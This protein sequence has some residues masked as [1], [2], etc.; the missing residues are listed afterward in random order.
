MRRRTSS[1]NPRGRGPDLA[2]A[3]VRARSFTVFVFAFD[4]GFGNARACFFTGWLG[5][6]LN[7]ARKKWSHLVYLGSRLACR[8]AL[9][10]VLFRIAAT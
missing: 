1:G 5:S 2:M 6:T 4:G 10:F 8:F 3:P 7:A 9:L